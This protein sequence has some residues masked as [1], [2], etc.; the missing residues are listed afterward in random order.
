ML[1][2][3]KAPLISAVDQL[4]TFISVCCAGEKAGMNMTCGW[5]IIITHGLCCKM[6]YFMNSWNGFMELFEVG[7]YSESSLTF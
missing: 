7:D 2:E 1:V 3:K 5:H 4:N 6:H